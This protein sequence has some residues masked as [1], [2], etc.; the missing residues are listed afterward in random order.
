[1]ISLPLVLPPVV[2]RE[3]RLAARRAS[4]Y[5]SRVG[6]A[7]TGIVIAALFFWNPVIMAGPAG[8]TAF[9]VM[10]FVAAWTAAGTV[11]QLASGA[12]AR[13]KRED[14][15][16][17]LFL[18]PLRPIDIVTGKLVSTSLAAFYRFLAIV[19]ALGLPML[20]GGVSW[21]DFLLL[22]LALMNLTFLGATLGLYV[23]ARHWDEK[24][25]GTTAM[26]AMLALVGAVPLL[27]T[28]M[29]SST[30]L[31]FEP[32]LFAASP[33]YPIWHAMMG[34][35]WSSYSLWASLL[36]TQGLAWG[37]FAATC[38]TLPTCWQA[39]PESLAPRGDHLQPPSPPSS[40]ASIPPVITIPPAPMR[41]GR[42]TRR[43]ISAPERTLMLARNP[44]LWFANRWQTPSTAAWVIGIVVVLT[45]LPFLA[46]SDGEAF[47]MPGFALYVAFSVNA[48][49]KVYVATQASAAFA[50]DRGENSLEL[51][52]STPVSP[53]TVVEGHLMALRESTR[54]W[55][56]IVLA[57]ETVWMGIAIL[58]DL[59]DTTSTW[60]M[61][62][63][64]LG[65]V[66]FVIPDLEALRWTALWQGVVAKNA[67]EAEKET[68]L[69]VMFLP[70]LAAFAVWSA[71]LGPMQDKAWMAVLILSCAAASAVADRWFIR[72]SRQRLE[73][74][75]V[76]W[77]QRRS[78]GDF[79]HYDRWRK[80]GRWLG[81]W[82]GK[83]HSA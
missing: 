35:S 58:G 73:N 2:D 19:P 62:L 52:L 48:V 49:I 17:L 69:R 65:V 57:I 68:F 74:E 42:S 55:L 60:L 21:R 29:A 15:L 23:S 7:S 47:L 18:T 40:S 38:R 22:V 20:A 30:R 14:T 45:M 53:R 24:R 8:Q 27:L 46:I 32:Y 50:R 10:A 54:P 59:G 80:L 16:G 64:G 67:Q 6:A 25:A 33:A 51:L 75:L 70:W 12:F 3:L 63:A 28:I 13:E 4:T 9:R 43:V 11:V 78:A 41:M 83:R 72:Q 34:R 44:F 31:P 71:T 66:G 39:R 79:E 76:L 56:W 36:I 81:R 82:W 26:V 61:I 37:F 1:M 5:W 77:A